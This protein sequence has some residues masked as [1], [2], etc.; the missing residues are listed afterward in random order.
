MTG[1]N[2][3]FVHRRRVAWWDTDAA[4]IAYTA[5]FPQWCMEAIEEWFLDRLGIDWYR[6]NHDMNMGSPFVHMSMDMRSSVTPRDALDT[7]V[8]LKQAGRSS[9]A[10]EL[11][12]RTVADRRVS[13]EGRYVCVFVDRDTG[14]ARDIPECFRAAVAREVALAAGVRG[15]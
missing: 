10:F 14:K 2:G 15:D 6:L 7:T 3:L 11:V 9:L 1:T 5:R 12:G 4:N 8:A 13:F